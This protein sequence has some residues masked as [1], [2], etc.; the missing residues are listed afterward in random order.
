[1]YNVLHIVALLYCVD[2]ATIYVRWVIIQAVVYN[3]DLQSV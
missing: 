3:A 2:Y 1:M